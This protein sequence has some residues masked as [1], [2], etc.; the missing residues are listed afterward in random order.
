MPKLFGILLTL[1]LLGALL[2][3]CGAKD[4]KEQTPPQDQAIVDNS[5]APTDE[6]NT[7]N[8]DET[9]DVL[10]A[11]GRYVGLADSNS[12]E[13]QLDNVTENEG[14]R[15]FKLSDEIKADFDSLGLET[16]DRVSIEYQEVENAQPLLLKI[17]KIS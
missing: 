17:E 15:V 4:T 10:T 7:N 12:A 13:I 9:A 3:A 5:G 14:F 1:L 8:K 16:N 11:I 6:D 2:T